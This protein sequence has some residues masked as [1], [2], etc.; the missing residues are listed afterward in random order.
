MATP[1]LGLPT[2]PTGATNISIAY[3]EA[4][5]IID[6]LLPLVVQDKD[7]TAPP[8]TVSGDIGKRWLPASPA[9]GDWAG[10]ENDI[11]LCTA[12]GVWAYIPSPPYIIAYVI[13]EAIEYRRVGAA[14]VPV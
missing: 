4:V 7:L 8:T 1:I 2:T 10:H 12:A 13:D 5:K 11:A 14:W 9:T 6:A 3:N